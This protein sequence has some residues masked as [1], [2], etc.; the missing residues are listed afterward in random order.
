MS[1]ALGFASCSDVTFWA[2]VIEVGGKHAGAAGGIL[3]SGGNIGGF[4][5]PILTPWIASRWDWT[6][7]LYFGSLM[8]L[9]GVVT[10]LLTDPTRPLASD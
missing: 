10:W 7:G 9:V 4:L 3:N 6:A 2:G 5:A 1:L 8:A